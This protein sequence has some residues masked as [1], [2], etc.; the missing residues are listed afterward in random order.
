MKK[1]KLPGELVL[2]FA[3]IFNSL[4]VAL[5]AK[6]NFGISSISSVPYVFSKA[7]TFFTFGTWNYLFQTALIITLMIL[8]KKINFSYL[9]SFVVGI[10]FGKMLDVHELWINR[11]PDSILLHIV[12]FIISFI[13]IA[14]GICMSNNCLLPIIPTDVFPR[15]LSQIIR[16]PYKKVKTFYDLSC[17]T[18]TLL[19][20]VI[21]LHRISG[22]GLGTVLCAFTT[23]KAVS[24]VQNFINRHMEFYR[25]IPGKHQIIRW[26]AMTL[27]IKNDK[28]R[29]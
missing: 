23:G 5:M 26:V 25:I 17:L 8:R 2:C 4:G 13:I 12:Y 27:G 9:F 1:I 24:V 15:D 20:S 19:I 14:V 28:R 10:C 3:V 18:A 22:I 21:I 29:A 6:S 16:K 11:L 7:F